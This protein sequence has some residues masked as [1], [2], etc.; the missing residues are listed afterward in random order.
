MTMQ[1]DCARAEMLAGAIALGETDEAQRDTYRNHLATCAGCRNDLGGEREIERVMATTREARDSERWEPVLRPAH[2]RTPARRSTWQW[3]VALAA[4]A[5]LVV[6]LRAIDKPSNGT[7]VVSG[8]SVSSAQVA[9][10]VAALN[11]Q[12]APRRENQAESL[13]FAST[14]SST[15]AVALSLDVRGMPKQCTVTKS[16]GNRVLDRAVCRA[17]IK[18][19]SSRQS[20]LH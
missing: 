9:R 3:A 11:T 17:A 18:T 16:S 5:A 15:L 4:A 19:A 14:R 7:A 2:M 20:P 12:T 8:A 6:G 13:S 1:C 10:A